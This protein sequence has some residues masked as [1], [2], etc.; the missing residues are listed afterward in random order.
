MRHV[1]FCSQVRRPISLELSLLRRRNRPPC[2]ANASAPHF[3]ACE[4]AE[5]ASECSATV[6]EAPRLCYGV[7][8][9]FWMS[10][11]AAPKLLEAAAT[12]PAAGH[13]LVEPVITAYGEATPSARIFVIPLQSM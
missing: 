5:P 6:E 7:P 3:A 10:I 2:F 12:A 11:G 9:T 4:G 8:Q 13:A 1:R